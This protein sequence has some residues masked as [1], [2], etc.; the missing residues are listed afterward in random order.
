MEGAL[1]HLNEIQPPKG[2]TLKNQTCEMLRSEHNTSQALLIPVRQGFQMGL[3][4][5]MRSGCRA[6]FTG[7]PAGLPRR[8][9]FFWCR[10]GGWQMLL[11]LFIFSENERT[12]HSA[13]HLPSPAPVGK[14][15]AMDYAES[16]RQR[17]QL[18]ER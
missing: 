15:I 3:P 14:L 5:R 10:R 1:R 11:L 6:C 16:R 8:G 12:A 17:A 18:E 2:T 7:S 13:L 9:W 4:W